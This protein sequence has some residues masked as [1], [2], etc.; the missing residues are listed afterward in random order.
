M[1]NALPFEELHEQADIEDPSQDEEEAV[2]QTDAGIESWE[3]KVVVITDSSDHCQGAHVHKHTHRNVSTHHEPSLLPMCYH[4][5]R[6]VFN[7]GR[8]MASLLLLLMQ[9]R[10]Q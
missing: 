9:R 3:V 7:S 10:Q 8:S 4:D 5:L 2:P 1:P 6:T